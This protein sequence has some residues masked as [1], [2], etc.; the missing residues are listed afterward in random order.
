MKKKWFL[1][2]FLFIL[3]TGS[4]DISYF[5]GSAD[6]SM[7]IQL[8]EAVENLNF[9]LGQSLVHNKMPRSNYMCAIYSK[10]V[11]KTNMRNYYH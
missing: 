2:L 1:V 9:V 8:Q 7:N 3:Y 6:S 4:P 5:L 10:S 11:I